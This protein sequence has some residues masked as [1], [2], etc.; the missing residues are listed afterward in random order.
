MTTNTQFYPFLQELTFIRP[1]RFLS[2]NAFFEGPTSDPYTTNS[3]ERGWGTLESETF[4][5]TPKVV[6]VG[7]ANV[8][9]T[10]PFAFASRE[11]SIFTTAEYDEVR[12]DDSATFYA[13]MDY[14]GGAPAIETL[15]VVRYESAEE[16]QQALLDGT[17]DVMWGD[18]VLPARVITDIDNKNDPSLN[19]FIGD[20]IMNVLLT[21]NTGKPPLDD[22]RVRK[23]IIHGIDK[24]LLVKK[25]LGGFTDPVDNVFPRDIPY[26]DVDLTPHWDYDLEKAILLSCNEEASLSA[27]ESG[28]SSGNN[29][30]AIGLGVGLGAVAL[31]A[32]GVALTYISKTKALEAKYVRSDAA[33][34][35]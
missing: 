32:V 21:L 16:I 28:S 7:T 13:N 24:K 12:V 35:A 26:C 1:I 10:G 29:A 2:P 14:W 9:G 15:K 20:D 11:S 33:T 18:G 23:A 19:V 31:V 17:L 22:I 6:C 34:S 25:E 30:L 27:S 8:S 5:G 3:C 4:P